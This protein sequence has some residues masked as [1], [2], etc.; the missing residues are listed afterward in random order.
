MRKDPAFDGPW[1]VCAGNPKWETNGRRVRLAAPEVVE[2]AKRAVKRR[3][4]SEEDLGMVREFRAAGLGWSEIGEKF[5]VS[6]RAVF[7]V[8]QREKR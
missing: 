6:G 1:R 7:S 8:W 4:W 2:R 3:A 5:G